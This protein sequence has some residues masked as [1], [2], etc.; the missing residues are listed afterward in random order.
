[1]RRLLKG[2]LQAGQIFSGRSALRFM[3]AMAISGL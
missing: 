2:R 1:L 3:R